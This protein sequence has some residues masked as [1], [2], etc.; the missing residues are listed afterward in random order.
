[1][2]QS[3]YP[4]IDTLN[5]AL[6][7]LNHLQ[8]SM[9]LVHKD[10][11]HILRASLG[12]TLH[13]NS[14]RKFVGMSHPADPDLCYTSQDESCIEIVGYCEYLPK[15]V[16]TLHENQGQADRALAALPPRVI[17]SLDK[18]AQTDWLTSVRFHCLDRIL[19]WPG[20]SQL[21]GSMSTVHIPAVVPRLLELAKERDPFPTWHKFSQ[22]LA[23]YRTQIVAARGAALPIRAPHDSVEQPP[24]ITKRE[25]PQPKDDDER[26]IIELLHS[27]GHRLT[28]TKLLAEFEAKGNIKAESTIKLKL[29][30]M[31]D[32]GLLTNRHDVRPFKGYG[33]PEWD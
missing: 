1:M 4:D 5:A 33:L 6:E 20:E 25:L 17:S 32:V 21:Q 15:Y 18:L 22:L 27:V 16:Q 24:K 2:S 30:R 8:V 11:E 23:A 19:K 29:A 12:Y 31:V 3:E 9:E 14:R 28:T 7:A 13:F 10:L 26:E